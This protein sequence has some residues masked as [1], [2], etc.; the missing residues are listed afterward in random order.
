MSE[1]ASSSPRSRRSLSSPGS[2]DARRPGASRGEAERL[3]ALRRYDVHASA[4]PEEAFDRLTRLAARAFDAPLAMISFVDDEGQWARSFHNP[5]G[6]R[7]PAAPEREQ[8][9]CHYAIQSGG[10]MVIEDAQQDARF[11]E[12]PF[13]TGPPHVRFY[14]GAPLTTPEGHRLGTICVL[15]VQPRTM[16]ADDRA[17][18]RDLAATAMDVLEKHRHHRQ[19]QQPLQNR[20]H[21]EE[22]IARVS[23]ELHSDDVD[24][25]A[26]LAL[27]GQAVDARRAFIFRMRGEQEYMNNMRSW[28]APGVTPTPAEKSGEE[29]RRLS[30]DD[31]PYW[32]EQIQTSDVVRLVA[33]ELP[34]EARAERRRLERYGIET[35]LDVPIRLSDGTLYGHIGFDVSNSDRTWNADD[36]HLLHVAADLLAGHFDRQQEGERF[37]TLVE[38]A[39]GIISILDPDGTLRYQNS[40][41]ERTL[42]YERDEVIGEDPFERIHPD[43]RDRVRSAFETLLEEPGG[44]TLTQF[45]TRHADGSWVHLETMA[46]NLTE[47]PAVQGV[48]LNSRDVTDRKRAEAELRES[49]RRHRT[50]VERASDIMTI[51]DPDGTVRYQ[52]PSFREVLGRAPDE[53]K[54]RLVFEGMHPGDRER[55]QAKFEDMRR[56]PGSIVTI[57]FR[58]RHADGSWVHLESLVRNLTQDP[59]IEGFVANTRDVTEREKAR[60][61]LR[62]SERKFRSVIENARDVIFRTDAEGRWTLL[63]PS[64]EDTLG[65]SVEESLGERFLKYLHPDD[66]DDERD[67]FRRRLKDPDRPINT[68][69]RYVTQDGDVRWMHVTARFMVDDDGTVTGT[70]GTL[71]DVTDSRRFE[72]ERRA[73]ERAEELL[74]TKTAFLNN[75]SH[76]LRTPLA[77]ILGFADVLAEEGEGVQEEFAERITASGQRLQETLDSVLRLAQLEGDSAD[78]EIQPVPVAAEVEEAVDLLQPLAAEKDL[79]LHVEAPEGEDASQARAALDP[80]ALHRILNNLIGNAIKFTDEG[81]VTVGVETGARTVRIRVADTGI[82]ISEDFLPKLF[83]DFR[84]E[85]SG[86]ERT[87]EGSGLGLT[88]TR[89]LVEMMDG[90]IEVDSTHGEGSV[91]TVTFPRAASSDA[92]AETDADAR[93]EADAETGN[94]AEASAAA[95]ADESTAAAALLVVEDNRNTRMLAEHVL[96]ERYD[97]A[98]VSNA[99]AACAAA[100]ERSFDAF[101]IDINLG[102][103]QDGIELLHRLRAEPAHAE[104]P[105]VAVTA[106]AMPGDEQ[107]FREAGFDG[108]VG[109]PFD[110]GDLLAA[111]EAALGESGKVEAG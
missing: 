70:T 81:R 100:S 18:L 34:E 36:E 51:L 14:A 68:D 58:S 49:E 41:G 39:S 73:R 22:T 40:A 20:T 101:L 17:H 43:H 3:R 44:S 102:P 19:A 16:S 59:V 38:R 84:Q 79:P 111:V 99:E 10:V 95:P 52:S 46:R 24:L 31:F 26:V 64:W 8:S 109:K 30:P 77:S 42:G 37:H 80:Q 74:K 45:R 104:V 98:A 85:S 21:L 50:L 65:Y 105:A 47:H 76:E 15:D 91:F 103:D 2:A 32:F 93:D 4:P 97:V 23:D 92:D 62:Q 5:D 90:A 48:V 35:I 69:V 88:I 87:H 66:R 53:L 6:R 25:D 108:Y 54:G 78:V 9:F 71:S 72:A 86:L 7:K 29:K 61:R 96:G 89:R 56:Q 107:Q 75:M 12:A 55:V 60:E 13:V 94:E 33:S 57:Q 83:D 27:L 110:R 67:T 1:H 28:T 82:G 63:S 11:S 106:H